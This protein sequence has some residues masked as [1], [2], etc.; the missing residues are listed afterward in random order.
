MPTWRE[1]INRCRTKLREARASQFFPDPIVVEDIYEALCQAIILA[2]LEVLEGVNVRKDYPYSYG[3]GQHAL[4][5]D[6]LRLKTVVINGKYSNY[7]DLDDFKARITQFPT[8]TCRLHS[9]FGNT[10]YTFPTSD[11]IIPNGI[12]IDYIK[13]PYRWQSPADDNKMLEMPLI[14]SRA[15]LLEALALLSI[16]DEATLA[17][18]TAFENAFLMTIRGL[19]EM[20]GKT[21]PSLGIVPTEE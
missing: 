3:P 4:P 11:A 5:D 2:P 20:F 7:L 6:F 1:F 14:L 15:V 12:T 10:L 19:Y 21:P 17:K 18:S 16:R 8:D 13:K 9:K